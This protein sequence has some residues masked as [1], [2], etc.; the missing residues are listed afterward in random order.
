MI[1][2]TVCDIPP[3]RYLVDWRIFN[4]ILFGQMGLVVLTPLAMPES[5]RS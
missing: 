5:C 4:W 2:E 1:A 3:L